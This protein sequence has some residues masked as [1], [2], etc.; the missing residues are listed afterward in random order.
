[1][2]GMVALGTVLDIATDL[3]CESIHTCQQLFFFLRSL[4]IY[5]F[6]FLS[7]LHSHSSSLARPDQLS[8]KAYFRHYSMPLNRD[9]NHRCYTY[10]RNSY[11]TFRS[12]HRVVDFLEPAGSLH[13]SHY[14]VFFGVSFLLCSTRV[15]CAR[16]SKSAEI[17]VYGQE[18][19]IDVSV[20]AEEDSI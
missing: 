8:S 13:G 20:E 7:N 12:G 19:P 6:G 2:I 14:G 10:I 9:G 4:E 11:R 5:S 1:M 17:L 3:L 16:G 15:T 18:K